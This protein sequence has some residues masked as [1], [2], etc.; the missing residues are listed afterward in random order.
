[1]EESKS[2]VRRIHTPELKRAVLN[3]CRAG[4]S[5]ARVAMAYGINA[6]LV[7][8][9]RR[10]A[11]RKVA[12]S[13]IAA[14]PAMPTPTFIPMVI[15]APTTPPPADVIPQE[16]FQE[17]RIELRGGAFAATVTWPM[18]AISECAGWLRKLL[19]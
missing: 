3:E 6:N 13:G 15:G 9:W 19:L 16:Q 1:M 4:I 14:T 17:V 7:H 10:F 2:S 5:V 12:E 11:Q 8:K 18:S